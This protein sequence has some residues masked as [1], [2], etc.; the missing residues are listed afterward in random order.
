MSSPLHLDVFVVPSKPIVGLIPPM[1]KGEATWP[2]T[3]VSLITGERDAVLI[4][5]ALTPDDAGRVVEWIRAT[6]KNLTTIYITHGHGDHFFGLNTILGAFPGARAVTAAAIVP[7]AQGQLSPD[8]MSFWTAIFPGQ[9]PEHPIM[10]DALDGDVIDLEGHQLR[11]ITVGQ[12]DTSPSTI[13]Y[14]P[15][16]DA[17]ISGDIAYNGIHQWLTQTDHEKR[18]QWITSVEQVE[19]LNPRIVVAGHKRPDADDDDPAAIPGNTKTYIRDFDQLLSESHSAQELVDKMMSLHGDLG[20]PY[21]LWTA[22][23][24]VFEQGQEQHHEHTRHPARSGQ[25]RVRHRR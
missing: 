23:Q 18:M 11:I 10:P 4:D 15:S 8:F 3:S 25:R 12:S 22:A 13:V 21:T 5:A 1:G 9:I 14:I 16:L 6:G 2:A 20:N 7:E 17:V 24:S 19:A